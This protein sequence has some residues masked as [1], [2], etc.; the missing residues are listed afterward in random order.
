LVALYYHHSSNLNAIIIA[1]MSALKTRLDTLRADGHEKPP[2]SAS[3]KWS[4]AALLPVARIVVNNL[5]ANIMPKRVGFRS[6]GHRAKPIHLNR[7]PSR[8]P[9]L[10]VLVIK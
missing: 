4:S 1:E 9:D 5:I 7:D 2:S 10:A 6:S 8:L 3:A